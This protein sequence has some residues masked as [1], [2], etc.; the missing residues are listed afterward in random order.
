MKGGDFINDIKKY[1]KKLLYSVDLVL[2]NSLWGNWK[3]KKCEDMHLCLNLDFFESEVCIG[4][5]SKLM[6]SGGYSFKL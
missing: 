6:K 5:K 4:N 1:L 2:Q 3:R